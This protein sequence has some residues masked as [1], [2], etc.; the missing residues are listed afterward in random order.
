[1]HEQRR[2]SLNF[3][4]RGSGLGCGA[5]EGVHESIEQ[6]DGLSRSYEV[7]RARR[8]AQQRERRKGQREQH[9]NGEDERRMAAR[10][11]RAPRTKSNARLRARRPALREHLAWQQEQLVAGVDQDRASNGVRHARLNQQREAQRE[12]RTRRRPQNDEMSRDFSERILDSRSRITDELQRLAKSQHYLQD[13]RLVLV[14]CYCC[15]V[16]YIAEYQRWVAMRAAEATSI[17]ACAACVWISLQTKSDEVL[18][19]LAFTT[20]CPDSFC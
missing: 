3:D 11:R 17:W 7:A 18:V 16:D 4:V 9:T 12:Q 14:N 1:M 2:A 20:R 8:N 10:V 5:Q 15:G 13:P 19:F 6:A